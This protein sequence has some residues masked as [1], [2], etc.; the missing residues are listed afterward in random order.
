LTLDGTFR[1]PAKPIFLTFM[2]TLLLTGVC[3]SQF[4]V[5]LSPGSGSPTTFTYISGRGFSPNAR[6]DFYFDTLHKAFTK[7]DR[8]GAFF[9]IGIEIP[10]SAAPG[11]HWVSAVQDSTSTGAQAAFDV[12]TNWLTFGFN[13]GGARWNPY[14]YALNAGNVHNLS[15]QWV[16]PGGGDG[17]SAAVLAGKVFVEDNTL[18]ALGA[19]NGNLLWQ[20]QGY[21]P[22][23]APTVA[24]CSNYEVCKNEEIVFVG[25]YLGGFYAFYAAT[26]LAL[27]NSFPAGAAQGFYS[28]PVVA[29]GVVYTGFE[30]GDFYALN[31]LTGDV[32]WSIAGG[33]PSAVASAVADGVVYTGCG[34]YPYLCALNAA[35]GDLL[36]T[37]S[38][39]AGTPAV[40]N[41][42]V[43]TT[44]G[45][46][47]LAAVNAA[48]G[49]E[50]WYVYNSDF[51]S[52]PAVANGVVYVGTASQLNAL[53]A[54]NGDQ[55]WS[56]PTGG[57]FTSAPAVA[58]GVVYI[59]S[60]NDYVYAVNASNGKL[61]WQYNTG[62]T[63]EFAPVVANGVLYA[64]SDNDN[65]YAFSLPTAK[66][67]LQTPTRPSLDSLH[68][69]GRQ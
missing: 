40:A 61:L 69:D 56:F 19:T 21:R 33:S 28:S 27:W 67:A 48:T 12:N 6:I 45:M 42:V 46:G 25:D 39:P 52:A 68:W 66:H 57:E 62:Q 55:L 3:L 29:N 5:T 4:S 2:A 32:I 26:G 60:S 1:A 47:V 65:L 35:N 23:S 58:N 59:G 11:E 8:A 16:Y 30:G 50:L 24:R 15:L 44:D 31:A 63:A 41:G 13:A 34:S 54:T 36:W 22:M 17:F 38:A 37:S 49:A 53:N 14:E 51:S 20:Y 9:N 18:Y 43:Y 7:A 64:G 10:K